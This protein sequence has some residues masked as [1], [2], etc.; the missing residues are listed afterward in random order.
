MFEVFIISGDQS[1]AYRYWNSFFSLILIKNSYFYRIKSPENLGGALFFETNFFSTCLTIISSTLNDC[2]CSLIGGSIFFKSLNSECIMKNCCFFNSTSSKFSIFFIETN[3]SF[4]SDQCYF[5]DS[6]FSLDIDSS[7]L[8]NSLSYSLNNINSSHISCQSEIFFFNLNINSNIKFSSFYNLKSEKTSCFLFYNLLTLKSSYLNL[9]QINI[10]KSIY[11]ISLKY[12]HPLV[13]F[14]NTIINSCSKTICNLNISY[15][16]NCTFDYIVESNSFF[17]NSSLNLFPITYAMPFVK[18]ENYVN[19]CSFTEVFFEKFDPIQKS[20]CSFW[21]THSIFFK[22]NSKT[23]GGA[24]YI[25]TY[26]IDIRIYSCSFINCSSY[27]QDSITYGGAIF[28]KSKNGFQVILDYI[29][30]ICCFSTN[31][32]F[33]YIDCIL[34]NNDYIFR[35]LFLEKC[36]NSFVL[37]SKNT[38]SV[39]STNSNFIYNNYSKCFNFDDSLVLISQNSSFS[40]STFESCQIYMNFLTIYFGQFNKIN[41]LNNSCLNNFFI[42]SFLKIEDSLFL[43]NTPIFKLKS[44]KSI[45]IQCSFDFQFN[46]IIYNV[47]LINCSENITG[48]FAYKPSIDYNF[49]DCFYSI[50]FKPSSNIFFMTI[51]LIVTIISFY[52]YYLYY[53]SKRKQIELENTIYVNT[54]IINDF[55]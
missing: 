5:G 32:N 22:I 47:S 16:E 40:Y 8:I 2:E 37:S 46:L 9:V 13:I 6:Y 54:H 51:I 50:P 30:S 17:I 20:Q 7:I 21:I 53:F 10:S 1:D 11:E 35:S 44:Q 36:S 33:A 28:L 3:K 45:F 15:F 34:K 25:G 42:L 27:S 52:I 38:L 18:C 49:R 43:Y 48:T 26:Y 39:K 41:W 23:S 31:S 12:K 24:I 19:F 14:R 4:E 55:G 29:C